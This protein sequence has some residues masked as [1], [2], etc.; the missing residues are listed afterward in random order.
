MADSMEN[1]LNTLIMSSF[2]SDF[3][4]KHY[5]VIRLQMVF[6]LFFEYSLYMFLRHFH[7]LLN[8]LF[9]PLILIIFSNMRYKNNP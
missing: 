7:M 9:F 3:Y 6:S 5:T 4:N 1:S 8:N 2:L